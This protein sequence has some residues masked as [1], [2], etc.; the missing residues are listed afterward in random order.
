MS[1]RGTVSRTRGICLRWRTTRIALCLEWEQRQTRQ[2]REWET[3][4]EQRCAEYETRQEQR[5]DRWEE[6]RHKECSSW[7][8]LLRWL[9]LVWTWVTTTVCRVWTW[10]TVT[11]C[12]LWTWVTVTI[13]KFWVWVTTTV[14]KLWTWITVAFCTLWVTV[15]DVFCGIVCFLRRLLAPNEVSESRSECIYG[16]TAAFRITEEKECVLQIVVRIRLQPDADVTQQQLQNAQ[17]TWEPAIERAWSGRFRIRRKDGDCPCEEYRVLV[18]VQWV[19]SGE[20][21]VVQVHSGSGRADMGNWFITSTGGTAAHEFGHMLGNPDEYPDPACPNR[22]VTNDNSIMRSSQTGQ[23]R[24]RHYQRF[25][26]WVS[27]YT[28]CDYEVA[29]D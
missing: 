28:C 26:D 25:A 16:W 1:C 20:H 3:R 4:Q 13:C 29:S 2:C 15:L 18:D 17:A 24:P 27:A 22:N 6:E 7:H 11:I 23:V 19:T 10:V 9:C 14:C 21:H 5:C 8:P 12:K